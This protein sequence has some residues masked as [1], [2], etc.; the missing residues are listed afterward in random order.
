MNKKSY[1]EIKDFIL[2]LITY[3]RPDFI[4]ED[5]TPL[6][7]LH[8]DDIDFTMLAIELEEK[9]RI[10]VNEKTLS[11]MFFFYEIVDYVTTLIN[12]NGIIVHNKSNN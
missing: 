6:G 7:T 2:Q 8:L 9:Y 5:A 11:E 3:I 1:Q 12:E 10:I 4:I